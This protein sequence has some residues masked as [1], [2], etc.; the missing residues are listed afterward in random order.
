MER[1]KRREGKGRR[2][3]RIGGSG[4]EKVRKMGRW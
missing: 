2:R 1:V 4:G 3:G